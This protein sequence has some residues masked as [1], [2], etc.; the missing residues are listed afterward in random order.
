[1]QDD[2]RDHTQGLHSRLEAAVVCCGV[3]LT[4]R[5]NLFIHLH[6][7]H[8]DQ[9]DMFS[10]HGFS[11][12]EKDLLRRNIK[13]LFGR[14]TALEQ[15]KP[16]SKPVSVGC[17]KVVVKYSLKSPRIRDQARVTTSVE[18]LCGCSKYTRDNSSSKQGRSSTEDSSYRKR[19][20]DCR[21]D[22]E[23]SERQGNAPPSDSEDDFN[24][25]ESPGN[26]CEEE[27]SKVADIDDLLD[28]DAETEELNQG[29]ANSPRTQDHLPFL[30]RDGLDGLDYSENVAYED[31]DV[32]DQV[33][34]HLIWANGSTYE[35]R[36][37]NRF[38][39]ND[40]TEFV[41]HLRHHDIFGLKNYRTLHGDPFSELRSLECRICRGRMIHDYAKIYYH[42]Y[43]FHNL[44]VKEYF[45]QYVVNRQGREEEG[46]F[47]SQPMAQNQGDKGSVCKNDNSDNANAEEE[48][49]EEDRE[50]REEEEDEEVDE[51]REVEEYKLWV[52]QCQI[53]CKHGGC[54]FETKSVI[55]FRMHTLS[56]HNQLF[57]QYCAEQEQEQDHAWSRVRYTVC[58]LCNS[59][60]VHSQ[61]NL[62]S[63]MLE[64]HG[65]SGFQYY[66]DNI[67]HQV[68]Y[69]G[70]RIQD[71]EDTQ[72]TQD[73]EVIDDTE[74]TQDTEDAED[75]KDAEDAGHSTQDTGHSYS[76]QTISNTW[77]GTKYAGITRNAVFYLVHE[78]LN[79]EHETQ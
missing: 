36:A 41:K 51:K 24:G 6:T 59:P 55:E 21:S 37:C 68:Q 78:T 27:R 13:P 39:A 46:V 17:K 67:K 20:T 38:S 35:C 22:D 9:P 15:E 70:H 4:T 14:R 34:P 25:F 12:T 42:L 75:T 18:V 64:T 72:D 61:S 16:V 8:N 5:W 31:N 45:E 23:R 11:D 29:N 71:T 28:S 3:G 26:N 50:E 74:D 49:V 54:D 60:V 2:L 44:A 19:S 63:H 40:Q 1:M 76:L 66:A 47:S 33:G 48:E 52:N 65:M 62:N 79:I 53:A 77:Y 56:A 57:E 73:S 10:D 69:I 7:E 43:K 58:L 32:G 30:E